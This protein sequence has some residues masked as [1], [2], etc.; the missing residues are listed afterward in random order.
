MLKYIES[1]IVTIPNVNKQACLELN[2]SNLIIT[3]RNGSGK[4]SFIECIYKHSE[5]AAID[6]EGYDVS[7]L[8]EKIAKLQGNIDKGFAG[9][10]AKSLHLLRLKEQL[11]DIKEINVKYCVSDQ[12]EKRRILKYYQAFRTAEIESPNRLPIFSFFLE[13]NKERP[14]GRFFEELLTSVKIQHCIALASGEL[15]DEAANLN[16]YLIKIEKDLQTLFE[17]GKLKLY[18]DYKEAKYYLLNNGV[19]KKTFQNLSSGHSSLLDIYTDIMISVIIWGLTPDDIEGIV[20]IDEIDAHLH[21]SLQKKVL[22]F[23]S[24]SFPKIQ[25]IVSTHSPFVVTSVTDAVIYDLSTNESVTDVSYYSYDI[26]L[27]ELFGVDTV[28]TVLSGK[29]MELSRIINNLN[30]DNVNIAKNLIQNLSPSIKEMSDEARAL[31][32]YATL[33]LRNFISEI[34]GGQNV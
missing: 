23:F 25:F 28:S 11:E 24:K 17:D 22:S 18:F 31:I 12:R 19:D 16:A 32:N 10:T 21:V 33:K 2:G 3:G 9:E 6:P 15:V 4:T 29:L 27:Q 8:V 26:I 14:N 1:L 7:S 30:I 20:F 5:K 13:S 34:D